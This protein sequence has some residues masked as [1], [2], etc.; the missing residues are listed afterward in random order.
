MYYHIHVIIISSIS[1]KAGFSLS[2]F[3][4]YIYKDIERQYIS[5]RLDT[6]RS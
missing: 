5:L 4:E 6:Y 1:V 3:H 2:V